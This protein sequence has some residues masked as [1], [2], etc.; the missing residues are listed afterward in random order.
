MK[1][2]ILNL[3]ISITNIH[4]INVEKSEEKKIETALLLRERARAR[5]REREQN[6]IITTTPAIY[7]L[8]Q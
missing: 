4:N 8:Q 2:Q 5:D 6:N 1:H 7:V 3:Y